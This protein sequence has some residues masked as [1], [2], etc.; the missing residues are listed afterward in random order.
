MT[1]AK[2]IAFGFTTFLLASMLIAFAPS[3]TAQTA[4]KANVDCTKVEDKG[5]VLKAGR[6]TPESALYQAELTCTVKLPP[7]TSI[8]P[9]STVTTTFTKNKAEPYAILSPSPTVV[10]Q[11]IPPSGGVGASEVPLSSVKSTITIVINRKAPAFVTGE[12]IVHVVSTP[13][14][15]T[16]SGCN[17]A[18]S[19]PFPVT[20]NIVN[21]YFPIME[22]QPAKY[23]MKTGQNKDVVFSVK[24]TNFGNGD[25][26]V[27]AAPAIWVSKS[28]LESVIPPSQTTLESKA[29]SGEKALFSKDVVISAKTPHSNG[30]TNSIY[31]FSMAFSATAVQTGQ[32]IAKDDQSLT[33]SVQVQGVY[34]P[35]FDAASM[36]G[37]LGVGLVL[38]GFVRRR[39]G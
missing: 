14:A 28:K 30:Y 5:G 35:G 17:I 10:S 11:T 26:K 6:L 3:A 23:S 7:T 19:E 22:Y 37:A 36:I 2:I 16:T 21:D 15:S 38:L 12:Y 4:Q 27:T 9:A 1:A 24:V 34:V 20:I 32:D 39:V 33:L 29:I 8:C 25:T 18:P 31:T 13:A